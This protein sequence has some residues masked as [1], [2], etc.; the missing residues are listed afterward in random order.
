M[1]LVGSVSKPLRPLAPLSLLLTILLALPAR[2]QI[3]EKQTQIIGDLANSNIFTQLADREVVSSGSVLVHF[4]PEE[5]RRLEKN[6]EWTLL[7]NGDGYGFCTMQTQHQRHSTVRRVNYNLTV[8]VINRRVNSTRGREWY[9]VMDIRGAGD[10]LERD[11]RQCLLHG[12]KRPRRRPQRK[13]SFGKLKGFQSSSTAGKERVK[14]RSAP[15]VAMSSFVDSCTDFQSAEL[16]A[17]CTRGEA[18]PKPNVVTRI[19][20]PVVN[21]VIPVRC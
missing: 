9:P 17:P 21:D 6:D 14:L 10:P 7:A 8:K 18:F 13:I 4:T 19:V 20:K 3:F 2:A 5:V 16:F 12:E 11:F 15:F 1:P